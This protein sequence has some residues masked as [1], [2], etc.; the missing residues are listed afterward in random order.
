MS[1]FEICVAGRHISHCAVSLPMTPAFRMT[2][3]GRFSVAQGRAASRSQS[4]IRRSSAGV[5]ASARSRSASSTAHARTYSSSCSRSSSALATISSSSLSCSSRARWRPTQSHCRQACEKHPWPPPAVGRKHAAAPPAASHPLLPW[6]RVAF[7]HDETVAACVTHDPN[8]T[9]RQRIT[10]VLA[11]AASRDAT[12]RHRA[13]SPVLGCR[14][15]LGHRHVG[16]AR[17]DRLAR[18]GQ[19]RQRTV[20]GLI[21]AATFAPQGLCSPHRRPARR[22]LRAAQGVPRHARRAGGRHDDHRRGHR[23]RA[24]RPGDA[25]P[26]GPV[27]ERRGRA[28]R[29]IAAGDPPRPRAA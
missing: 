22:P 11:R 13:F 6:S 3:P 12:A 27:P 23:R 7:R 26:P 24:A 15:R 16:T 29:A 17:G 25:Q 14:R 21:A 18:R 1:R 20:D 2:E 5:R 19:Q 9:A 8:P 28:R 4:R 10:S